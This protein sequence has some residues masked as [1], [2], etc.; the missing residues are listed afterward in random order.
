MLLKPEDLYTA[1]QTGADL[2]KGLASEVA[3]TVCG[4]YRD[5][6]S[7]FGIRNPAGDAVAAL[8]SGVMDSFC[9]RLPEPITPPPPTV[10]FSGGQCCGV[11]Y[12]VSYTSTGRNPFSGEISTDNGKKNVT[13][14]VLSY[15]FFNDPSGNG[16]RDFILY[17]DCSDGL[18][19]ENIISNTSLPGVYQGGSIT[20]VLRRDGLPDNCGN[21]PA[22]YPPVLA[23]V[24]NPRTY[25]HTGSDG[26]TRP[27][28]FNVDFSAGTGFPSI[29]FPDL[30][31]INIPV[32]IDATG[33]DIDIP[34][35]IGNDTDGIGGLSDDDLEDILAG[36][37]AATRSARA[38][39]RATDGGG[40]NEGGTGED[41]IEGLYGVYFDAVTIPTWFGKVFGSPLKYRLG[42]ISFKRDGYHLRDEDILFAKQY[43]IAPADA[44]GYVATYEPE[45]VGKITVI[46]EVQE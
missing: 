20:G 30:P 5:Y 41:G 43:F 34:I 18:T 7:S 4:L 24:S 21:L 25:N 26:V 9:G 46:R 10:P 3:K 2:T 13:G 16:G 19:K 15:G 8:R 6:P 39:N 38:G 33:I 11:E 23:P 35:G 1:G 42:R 31:D 37:Q 17:V 32:R 29:S 45:V 14:K 22:E 40:D 27:I 12:E 36:A 44:N 28:N